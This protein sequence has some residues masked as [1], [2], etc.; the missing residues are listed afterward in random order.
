MGSI[1]IINIVYVYFAIFVHL[2]DVKLQ[3]NQTDYTIVNRNKMYIIY[4]T[5]NLRSTWED[6]KQQ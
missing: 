5:F 1:L 4:K 6:V 3:Q 2:N